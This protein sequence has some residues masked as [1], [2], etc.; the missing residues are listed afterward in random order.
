MSMET[1]IEALPRRIR[2][3]YWK[4]ETNLLD[5]VM[6]PFL[7]LNPECKAI[8][9]Q[10]D[11]PREDAPEEERPQYMYSV[12]LV[13]KCVRVIRKRREDHDGAVGSRQ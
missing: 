5:Y 7:K 2:H 12:Y 3:P 1:G 10:Y 8:L 13:G 4:N 6:E 9:V 11:G